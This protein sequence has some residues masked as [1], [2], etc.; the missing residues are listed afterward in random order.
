[1]SERKRTQLYNAHVAS[2]AS[3]VDFGG[4]EMPV[5]YPTGIVAEH[6]YTRHACSLFDVSHMGRLLIE[7]PER[8][9]FLQHV[10]TSNVA[11]LDVNR[12]QYCILPA[13]DGSA[14]DDAYLYRFE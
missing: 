5:Q 13:A 4:W 6:L 10:L 3:M 9:E 1:M 11:G 12:A 2:G 8:L 14:I 7:G